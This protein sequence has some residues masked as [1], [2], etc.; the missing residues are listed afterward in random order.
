MQMFN[1]QSATT[2]TIKCYFA[3]HL[4]KEKKNKFTDIVPT[5]SDSLNVNWLLFKM[6]QEA[7]F[8][9][10]EN[11]LPFRSTWVHFRFLVGFV[12]LDL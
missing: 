8:W 5:Y 10:Y 7:V 11:C 12:L 1:N 4:R 6:M 9:L 3:S 2:G